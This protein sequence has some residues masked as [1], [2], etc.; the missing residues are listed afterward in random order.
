M[1]QKEANLNFQT[2]VHEQEN[3][4]ERLLQKVEN[5]EA[6]VDAT[7]VEVQLCTSSIRHKP[8]EDVSRPKKEER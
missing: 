2:R 5:F 6:D 4:H 8:R 1:L 3:G 7:A